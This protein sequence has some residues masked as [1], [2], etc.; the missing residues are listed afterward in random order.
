[1]AQLAEENER[2]Y[3]LLEY[4]I[5]ALEK[6]NQEIE[7]EKEHRVYFSSI[8]LGM[9]GMLVLMGIVGEVPSFR[10]IQS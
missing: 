4:T 9:E 5:Q 6:A 7:G 2:L 8:R 3:Q 1:M 10:K